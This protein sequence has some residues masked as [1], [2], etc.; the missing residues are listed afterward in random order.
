MKLN[1]IVKASSLKAAITLAPILALALATLLLAACGSGSDNTSSTAEDTTPAQ[2]SS[3]LNGSVHG[4]QS[5]VSG[6]TVTLYAA[7]SGLSGASVLATTTSDANGNWSF[8]SYTCPSASTATY[9]IASGGNPGLAS[10]TNNSALKLAAALGACGSVPG[11]VN[12]DEVTTVAAAYALNGFTGPNGC[13]DCT[14]GVPTSVSNVH[15]K[16]P[17]LANAMGNAARL[18]SVTTGAVAAALPSAAACAASSPPANCSAVER[19]NSLANSL[20]ACVNSTGPGTAQC[21]E[22]FDCATP[23]ATFSSGACTVPGGSLATDT[24]TAALEIAR[25]PAQVPVAG[26]YD[27]ATRNPVFSPALGGAPTDWTLALNFTG[28][29]LSASSSSQNLAIDAAGNVWVANYGSSSLSE[30]SPAGVALTGSSGYTGGG[31]QQPYGLAIDSSG[32]VW[33]ANNSNGLSKFSA[34]GVAISGSSGYTG[35]GIAGAFY[36]AIDPSGNVWEVGGS[37]LAE[38]NSAGVALSGSS[39]YTGGGLD[40]PRGLAIDASGNVWIGGD[41]TSNN[42]SLI[43]FSSAGTVL[44]GSSGY[45]GGG[46]ETAHC[47]AIDAS[48]NIW[49]GNYSE[50]DLS[51]FSSAGT[52]LSGSNGYTGGGNAQGIAIDAGGNVWL[53]TGFNTLTEFNSAGTVLANSANSSG[54]SGGGLYEPSG[55]AIDSSGDVWTVNAANTTTKAPASLTEVIGAAVPTRTPLVSAMTNGFTP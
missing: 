35:G 53:A 24:L 34:T 14:S 37:V 22:L 43:E 26:V 33:V 18:A 25:N 5:P 41:N 21:V 1:R 50:T 30:F 46:L 32:N 3:S 55:I 44:S 49:L 42:S 4:G 47:L 2:A 19:L 23:G 45:T 8:S 27:V 38:F 36:V 52:P 15:G 6:S 7:G 9:L 28:G 39:G 10:G 29:G 12:I 54:Y 11:T 17:G 40:Y 31:I 13:V 51:E 16:N 20:A 48:G